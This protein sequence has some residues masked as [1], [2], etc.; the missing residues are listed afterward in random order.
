MQS[1]IKLKRLL[2]AS[3]LAGIAAALVNALVY[4]LARE[5]GAI[6]P[7]IIVPNAQ[8]P[9]TIV[10]VMVASFIPA[11]PAGIIL[12]ILTALTSRPVRYFIVISVILLVLSFYTPFT[13]PDVIMPMIVALNLMHVTAAAAIVAVLIKLGRQP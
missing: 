6:P 4:L 12:A 11:I 7:D 10:P 1:K 9:I 5:A 2:W 3:P 8:E 13:I